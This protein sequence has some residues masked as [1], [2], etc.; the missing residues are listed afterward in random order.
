MIIIKA[1]RI[2]DNLIDVQC[3]QLSC[4]E[5]GTEQKYWI[6]SN[7]CATKDEAIRN[8]DEWVSRIKT[9][10]EMLKIQIKELNK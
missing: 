4:N 1:K 3:Y 6:Y 2:V 5:Y 8:V 7:Q 10:A 9:Y